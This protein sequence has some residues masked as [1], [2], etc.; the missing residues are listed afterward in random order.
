MP[1]A[2]HL[3]SPAADGVGSNLEGV[4][5]EGEENEE[6]EDDNAPRNPFL[7]DEAEETDC[8]HC[9]E[10]MEPHH[11]VTKKKH[12]I[13]GDEE[14]A[15][16]EEDEP[17]LAEQAARE[18]DPHVKVGPAAPLVEGEDDDDE[19]DDD[20]REGE[21]DDNGEHGED[22]EFHTAVDETAAAATILSSEPHRPLAPVTQIL[23][24]DQSIICAANASVGKAQQVA[25]PFASASLNSSAF[26]VVESAA[27]EPSADQ[28]LV[29]PVEQSAHE[30]SVSI[31]DQSVLAADQS[32]MARSVLSPSQSISVSVAEETEQELIAKQL[33]QA[34]MFF[35]PKSSPARLSV[36]GANRPAAVAVDES[37]ATSNSPIGPV[38]VAKPSAL[39]SQA[40]AADSPLIIARKA[41]GRKAVVIS[42]DEEDA[43]PNVTAPAVVRPKT[44]TSV[45]PPHKKPPVIEDSVIEDESEENKV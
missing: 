20:Y 8:S 33:L 7:D 41:S 18:D 36:T 29:P 9:S 32:Q 19:E 28:T 22:T 6:E 42:D 15:C 2:A 10:E 25:E 43:P 17:E 23:T 5:D 11:G 21:C 4:E 16:N 13:E 40:A 3:G 14:D 1:L 12:I 34:G 31:A 24:A 35:S 26:F 38:I 45:A 37:F 30:R 27:A 44:A 39:V